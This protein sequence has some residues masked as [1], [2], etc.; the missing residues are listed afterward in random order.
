MPMLRTH[1]LLSCSLLALIAAGC[2]DAPPH[3][4]P[5]PGQPDALIAPLPF[6][7]REVMSEPADADADA[8]EGAVL[9][10]RAA[11]ARFFEAGGRLAPGQPF[12]QI[13]LLY[14]APDASAP[15]YRT[16]DAGGQWSAWREAQVTWSEGVMHNARALLDSPAQELELAP[17]EGMTLA[18]IELPTRRLVDPGAPLTRALPRVGELAAGPVRSVGQALAPASLVIPRSDWGARDPNKICGDVV[19]PYRATVHHTAS[20]DSDGPDPAARLRQMQAYHIDNNGWCDIG[21][22]FVV[23]QSG[24]I[25][26]GRSDER[27][28][29][30]HTGN[31]NAGNI[32]V[33]LIGNYEANQLGVAQAEAVVR[34]LGW[35]KQTYPGIV[36]TREFVKGHQ[37]WPGQNTD[38]PGKN[39]LSRLEELMAAAAGGGVVVDPSA[40]AVD[41]SVRYV[42]EAPA[43]FHAKGASAGIADALPG[44][45]LKAEIV[46]HN[47]SAQPLRG[48]KVDYLIEQP[49]VQATGYQIQS[50]Y[51]AKDGATWVLNDADAAP[52]NPGKDAMGAR[53]TLSMYAFG[54]G[55]SKRVLIELEAA[56]YSIGA[57]DHPDVRGWVRHI[58]DVYGEQ[59][60]WDQAPTVNKVEGGAALQAFTELDVLAP[61]QWSFDGVGADD[62]EGWTDCAPEQS[63][64][65]SNVGGA[66]SQRIKGADACIASSAWTAIDADSWD[67]LV[68]KVRSANG[69]HKSA[70]YWARDGEPFSEMRRVRF[71][72]PGDGTMRT[73][74]VPIGDHPQWTGSVVNLRLDLLDDAPQ[75]GSVGAYDVDAVYLQSAARGVSNVVGVPFQEG[76]PVALV[77]ADGKPTTPVDPPDRPGVDPGTPGEGDGAP[78]DDVAVNSG[79]TSAGGAGAPGG[80]LWLLALVGLVWRRRR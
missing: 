38:C 9:A 8:W 17:I 16:R 5:E 72:A 23:S 61:D 14:D 69:A 60:E 19:T 47:R 28:P 29:G 78:G 34:I 56:R 46:V 55:E 43:D 12:M 1:T 67:Q 77:G 13:N 70:I 39:V 10:D 80:A 54:A 15:R 64:G 33:S 71:E 31:Q 6:A 44:D 37:E 79:C 26:Q 73:L 7:A 42:D 74:V 27:R 63:E 2:G 21:Y 3:D 11:I 57:I 40:Y 48:V 25:Y 49:F 50:D 41:V 75:A 30:A 4:A 32:G 52:E 18:T 20:P 66:L 22:H 53:G 35:I 24:K 68:L 45:K 59:A 58:D 62:L 76:R 51:P 36:W 65:L